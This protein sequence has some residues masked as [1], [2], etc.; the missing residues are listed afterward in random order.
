M[1][2]DDSCKYMFLEI[3]K[4]IE[5]SILVES[6]PKEKRTNEDYQLL[7]RADHLIIRSADYY[8]GT[9]VTLNGIKY[10]V[11]RFYLFKPHPERNY[12]EAGD[13]E[14][15]A[16]YNPVTKSVDKESLPPKL[17]S[18]ESWPW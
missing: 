1:D 10:Q 18:Q 12:K 15:Y 11:Y 16:L 9:W 3:D 5:K 2:S 8:K 7:E 4:A 13:L 17:P 6:I 14:P